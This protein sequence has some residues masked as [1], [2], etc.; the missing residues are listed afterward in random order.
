M[1]GEEY[2]FVCS[3][4]FEWLMSIYSCEFTK[5]GDKRDVFV[6]IAVKYIGTLLFANVWIYTCEDECAFWALETPSRLCKSLLHEVKIPIT[7]RKIWE[8]LFLFCKFPDYRELIVWT[9]HTKV[10]NR[11]TDVPPKIVPKVVFKFFALGILVIDG[12]SMKIEISK[13]GTLLIAEYNILVP[14]EI[15]NEGHHE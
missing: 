9:H 1:H 4:T 13:I 12:E 5:E 6:H 10:L 7:A 11:R 8:I 2:L 14:I 3:Y 15:G